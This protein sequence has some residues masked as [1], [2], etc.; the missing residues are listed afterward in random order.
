LPSVAGEAA[1]TAF[2]FS[3]I[4]LEIEFPLE[5]IVFG[6]PV[7]HQRGNR[8][9]KAEWKQ[10]V[11]NGSLSALPEAHF[12]TEQP[13]AVTLYYFPNGRMDGDIDN[14]IKPT[15]DALTKHIYFDDNQIERIVV[16][17]FEP[18]RVF[19]FSAPS[20][21]LVACMLGRKPALY[22]QISDDLRRDI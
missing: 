12:C 21:T 8:R 15:L 4:C 9:A 13:L 3:S 17:K 7:S 2:I 5:F 11:K 1:S 14:I 20:E 19:S 6:T 18:D 16:Q 22:I 10:L